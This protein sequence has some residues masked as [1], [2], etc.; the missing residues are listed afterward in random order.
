VRPRGVPRSAL[1]AQRDRHG[2]VAKHHRLLL[3]MLQVLHAHVAFRSRVQLLC[4]ACQWFAGI[5]C[6]TKE[7]T[8]LVTG[9]ARFGLRRS[10]TIRR[11]TVQQR[12][13]YGTAGQTRCDR[14]KCRLLDRGGGAVLIS[15]L[16]PDVATAGAAAGAAAASSILITASEGIIYG[17]RRRG[18]GIVL[19]ATLLLFLC[20]RQ[21]EQLKY[22][23]VLFVFVCMYL[24]L[25]SYLCWN[26]DVYIFLSVSLSI[27]LPWYVFVYHIS[28]YLHVYMAYTHH[29]CLILARSSG[30][31]KH[32]FIRPSLRSECKISIC[33][34]ARM[35]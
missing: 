31:S 14:R 12:M 7:A 27:Y 9:T 10:T 19:C 23:R 20:A 30:T 11:C 16:D 33:T 24:N 6:H 22:R 28:Q 26:I 18:I 5:V 4:P 34:Y 15:D 13:R 25:K 3:D 32:A 17:K 8:A 1:H 21:R 2:T 29:Y 35:S